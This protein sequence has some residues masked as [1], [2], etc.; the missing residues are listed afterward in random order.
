MAESNDD[1]R[2]TAL[3]GDSTS[4]QKVLLK[5]MPQQAEVRQ[6]EDD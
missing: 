4:P 3:S 2:R 6:P 1:H 5:R